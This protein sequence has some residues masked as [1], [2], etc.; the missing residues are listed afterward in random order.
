MR[1]L[2]IDPGYEKIGIA[3]L[4]KTDGKPAYAPQGRGYG[5]V[6]ETLLFSECFK[7]SRKL[8]P[9][10]R[11]FALG[12]EIEKVIKKYKPEVLAIEK[13]YFADNQKTA[14]LVSEARGVIIY[15]ASRASLTVREFT[16][17]Q[18][19]VAVTGYGRGTKDQM[20]F[21]VE[22]LISVEKEI[23]EDDECDAI[24]LGLTYFAMEKSS[25]FLNAKF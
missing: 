4:E 25:K 18:A 8:L 21:M 17:L 23:K 1:V 15:E 3:V 5:E 2:A 13:L 14:M 16:P 11:L 6:K 9:H 7:T 20:K 22:K 12:K 24:A 10:E 19:K